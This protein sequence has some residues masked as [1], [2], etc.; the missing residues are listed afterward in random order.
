MILEQLYIDE[1]LT[2]PDWE[3]G[4]RKAEICDPEAYTPALS[5]IFLWRMYSMIDETVWK[6]IEDEFRAEIG[7]E[8]YDRIGWQ[9]NKPRL[10]KIIDKYTKNGQNLKGQIKSIQQEENETDSD[11]IEVEMEDGTILRVQ[12]KQSNNKSNWRQNFTKKF[13]LK[14]NGQRWKSQNQPNNTSRSNKKT[15]DQNGTWSCR[16]C[17]DEGQVRQ[18]PNTMRCPVHKH[19]PSYLKA[20][21][22]KAKIN[23]V[24]QQNESTTKRDDLGTFNSI[25]TTFYGDTDES[26]E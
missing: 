8:N 17:A 18:V 25:S 15:P 7:N 23:S 13:G 16:K 10:F 22:L 24:D 5:F 9:K 3:I 11:E 20:L 19:R 1:D 14:Q 26:T 12:P 4:D 2:F 21:P 6:K